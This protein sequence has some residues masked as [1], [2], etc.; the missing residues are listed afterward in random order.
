MGLVQKVKK[1]IST[2]LHRLHNLETCSLEKPIFSHIQPIIW[3]SLYNEFYP[4]QP[5]HR[6]KFSNNMLLLLGFVGCTGR[7]EPVHYPCRAVQ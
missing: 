3:V 7:L 6:H 2:P 1:V 5:V 4:V